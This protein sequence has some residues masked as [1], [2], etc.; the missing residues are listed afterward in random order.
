M[1]SLNTMIYEGLVIDNLLWMLFRR[2]LD[3]QELAATSS[4][5]ADYRCRRGPITSATRDVM[6]KLKERMTI[7]VDRRYR[8]TSFGDKTHLYYF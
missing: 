5:V 3:Y 4:R 1:L 8:N 6:G 7:G 2:C